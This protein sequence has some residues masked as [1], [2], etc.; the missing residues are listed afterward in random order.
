M[1]K[2]MILNSEINFFEFL[3]NFLTNLTIF[4]QISS[5]IE[6]FQSKFK[7]IIQT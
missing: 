7:K 6:Q 2:L 5:S 3:E 4:T 1:S